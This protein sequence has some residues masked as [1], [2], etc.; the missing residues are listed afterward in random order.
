MEKL[1]NPEVPRGHKLPLL[2]SVQTSDI[3][4]SRNIDALGHVRNILQ[5][6]GRQNADSVK[7]KMAIKKNRYVS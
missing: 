3:D 4:A 5:N 2:V 7:K 6:S 1:A